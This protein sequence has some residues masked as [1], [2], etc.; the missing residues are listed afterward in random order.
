M[1]EST[2]A[3]DVLLVE[4]ATLRE[5]TL[6]RSR[7]RFG[8]ASLLSAVMAFAF[9][10]PGIAP[11]ARWAVALSAAVVLL[12]VWLRLGWNLRVLT[13][14]LAQIEEAINSLLGASAPGSRGGRGLPRQ[15]TVL[16]VLV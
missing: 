7:S 6:M 4:Y 11:S 8:I 10:S 14:R 3:S 5:E 16:R 15:L 13:E 2:R 12:A 1:K 9:T